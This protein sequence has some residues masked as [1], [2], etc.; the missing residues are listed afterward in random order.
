MK[1]QTSIS[2]DE[3][4]AALSDVSHQRVSEIPEGWY[5]TGQLKEPGRLTKGG[6]SEAHVRHLLFDLFQAGKIERKKFII[7]NE[8]TGT[9]R[10]VYHYRLK[11]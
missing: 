8:K 11:K 1:K 5:T 4:Q 9:V 2:F 10:P 3:W 6:I 7:E